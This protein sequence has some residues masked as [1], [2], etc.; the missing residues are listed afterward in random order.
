MDLSTLVGLV[1]GSICIGIALLLGGSIMAY[2]DPVSMIIVIGGASAATL[3]SVP[4][5]RFLSLHRISLKT[6]RSRIKTPREQ[7]V[8]LVELAE[9][10]RRDGILALEQRMEDIKDPFLLRGIQL[11][12]DGVDPDSI[13]DTLQTEL[14][15]LIERHEAG[16][17][18]FEQ[19]GKYAPAFGMIGTL[20]GLVAMLSNME[21]PSAIGA[22]MAAALLTTLYGA[23]L[24][25]LVFLP[26]ADKLENRTHEE[27]LSKQ[28]IIQ[29]IKTIQLGDNP[30]NVE[31]NLRTFLAPAHRTAGSAYEYRQAA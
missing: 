13:E 31:M 12:V 3:T 5:A 25:N 1:I 9:V 21:D 7:V 20:I 6:L 14:D 30:R 10:A 16:R 15:N 23:L 28:M 8:E 19:M 2:V 18:M 27:S 29:G 11:A 17:N 26:L 4:L 22:G 24:A